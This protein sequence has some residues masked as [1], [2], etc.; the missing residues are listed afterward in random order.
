MLVS[1]CN[2][3]FTASWTDVFGYKSF[4]IIL[5]G[6]RHVVFTDY[7]VTEEFNE[8]SCWKTGVTTLSTAIGQES[9]HCL[10]LL[11]RS[12]HIAYGYWSDYH[13]HQ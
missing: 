9:P 6:K 3:F 1:S 8:V 12:H 4:K 7:I 5:E 13:Q 10:R 2:Q 11:I